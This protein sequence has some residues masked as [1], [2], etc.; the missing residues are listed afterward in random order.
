MATVL[1]ADDNHKIIDMLPCSY[2]LAS[3]VGAFLC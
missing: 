3:G 1:I 2:L